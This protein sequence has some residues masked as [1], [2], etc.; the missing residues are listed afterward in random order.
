MWDIDNSSIHHNTGPII[1]THRDLFAS[2]NIFHWRFWSNTFANNTNSGISIQLPDTYNLLWKKWHTFWMTENRFESN[3]KFEVELGGYFCFAN[4]SSNN[5]TDNYAK[6][7]S[8]ILSLR[9]MEKE[10]IMERNR[11][12]SNWGHWVVKMDITSQSLKRD[13]YEVP[14]YIQNNY[15]QMNHFI[16]DTGEYVDSWPRSYAVGVFGVQKADIHFNRLNNPLMD[17]EAVAG[18]KPHIP[19]TDF[20]NITHNWWGQN[21]DGAIPQR[22]F[23]MDD[24]NSLTIGQYSPY[25]SSKERFIDFWWDWHYVS[26]LIIIYF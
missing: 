8:G 13:G 21:S 5:F 1:D 3:T 18:C 11:F 6:W 22:I 10:L 12:Y 9:G 7:D 20:M 23:D 25:F 16:H 19:G 15:F 24:W 26:S 4:I 14:A 2:A 17:F